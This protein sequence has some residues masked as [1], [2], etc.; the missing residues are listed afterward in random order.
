MTDRDMWDKGHYRI[1]ER[2]D[3]NPE[4]HDYDYQNPYY[5]VQDKRTLYRERFNTLDEAMEWVDNQI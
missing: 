2:L 4:I 5:E 3:Y 1:S